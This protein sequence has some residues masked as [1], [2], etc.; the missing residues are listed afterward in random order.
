MN[1]QMKGIGASAGIAIGKAYL[2]VP[3]KFDINDKPINDV[4]AEIKLYHHANEI[5]VSQLTKIKD[6]A[7]SKIGA[8]KAEVFDAHIQIVNDPE[9]LQEIEK[10]IT[11]TKVNAPFAIDYVF[12]KYYEMFKNMTDSYFKERAA[13]VLDVKK[14]IL[15]NVLNVPLPNIMDINQ[16]VILIAH[17][18]TPSETA[19][20]DKKYVKGFITEIGGR[21]SHAA[22]MARTME[23]PAVLGVSNILNDVQNGMFIGLN[24]ISGEIEIEPKDLDV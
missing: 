9:M 12:N 1:K 18:L 23:I 13:D 17:D 6:I 20:L 14:R 7:V 4:E 10:T 22:I 16:E 3:P 24:G 2:L 19:L 8:D 15:S 21:T 11:S 5:S